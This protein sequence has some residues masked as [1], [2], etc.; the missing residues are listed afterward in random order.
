LW[1]AA[2]RHLR[3][4]YP[5]APGP[6]SGSRRLK[7]RDGDDVFGRAWRA[8]TKLLDPPDDVEIWI[9]STRD[10]VVACPGKPARLF[11]G[12]RWAAADA[13]E[14][15]L[16]FHLAR[17]LVLLG[18]DREHAAGA[19][20]VARPAADLVSALFA[21]AAGLP[22]SAEPGAPAALPRRLVTAARARLAADP[23]WAEASPDP[24]RFVQ[25]VRRTSQRVGLLAAGDPSSAVR[26]LTGDHG[27]VERPAADAWSAHDDVA[28]LVRWAVSESCAE[29]RALLGLAVGAAPLPTD[30]G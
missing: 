26:A 30:P 28:D 17:A 19:S 22:A 12:P 7:R 20:F 16:R 10:D 2:G 18:G 29:A 4:T 6:A 9:E 3:R 21:V 15:M 24:A 23:R 8:V 13:D 27:D 25:G 14:P 11:V 1:P 5:E